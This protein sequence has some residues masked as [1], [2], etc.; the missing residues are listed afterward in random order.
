MKDMPMDGRARPN[1]CAGVL[2]RWPVVRRRWR[3]VA[4][5]T[6]PFHQIRSEMVFRRLLR[7]AEAAS[8]ARATGAADGE[9][10]PPAIKVSTAPCN[11]IE[12]ATASS[13][14]TH[15]HDA[16][17]CEAQNGCACAYMCR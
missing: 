9:P 12:A 17:P 5:V 6:S 7:E 2:R 8:A 13:P 16:V 1:A 3:S 4:V 15:A 10:P 11:A 14:P